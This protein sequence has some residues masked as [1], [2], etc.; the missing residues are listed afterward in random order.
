MAIG[1]ITPVPI[2]PQSGTQATPN[3]MGDLKATVTNAVGAASYTTGGDAITA[4][5]LGL[6]RV[7]CADVQIQASTGTNAGAICATAVIQG[8]GSVLLKCF[9]TSGT[10]PVGVTEVAG[11][12]NLS[13]ITWQIQAMGV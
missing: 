2:T 4:A 10:S 12:V 5:Q 3:V 8:N 13:G 7:V 11:A 1:T 9:A 6:R